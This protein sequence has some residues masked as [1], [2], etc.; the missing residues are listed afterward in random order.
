M[1]NRF[2]RKEEL[3]QGRKIGDVGFYDLL[4]HLQNRSYCLG[5]LFDW[6]HTD[7]GLHSE[8]SGVQRSR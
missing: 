2:K 7:S 6:L 4:L 3:H 5:G 8:F 1:S